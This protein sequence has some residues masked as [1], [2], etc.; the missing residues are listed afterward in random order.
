MYFEAVDLVVMSIQNQPGYKIYCRLQDLL[1]KVA[2]H[3]EYDDDLA[4]VMNFYGG[5]LSPLLD[6]QLKVH[7]LQ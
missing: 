7:I 2:Q 3:R 6:A 4:F 5:D 1:L